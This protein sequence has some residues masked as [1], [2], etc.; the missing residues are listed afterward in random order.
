MSMEQDILNLET[1]CEF[2]GV[3]DRTLIKLLR[4]EHIPA[5][6]IGREWRFS[7]KALLDWLASGDS[8]NYSAQSDVIVYYNDCEGDCNTMLKEIENK[9][10]VLQK[11]QDVKEIL[12]SLEESLSLPQDVTL[13][14]SYKRKR[15]IEKLDFKLFWPAR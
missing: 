2:L 12:P 15:D 9:V 10:A 3:S 6:K 13:R 1:A 7:R 5:R 8:Y 11:Y 14:V 4:E